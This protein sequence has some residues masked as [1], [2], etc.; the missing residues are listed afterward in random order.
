MRLLVVQTPR[1]IP[2]AKTP[3][4]YLLLP[5][6]PSLLVGRQLTNDIIVA[7]KTVSRHHLEIIWRDNDLLMR[8]LG[9]ENGTSLNSQPVKPFYPV[10]LHSG[11]QLRLG[12]VLL[13]L[14]ELGVTF[15]PRA[16]PAEILELKEVE[17]EAPGLEPVHSTTP[18][19]ALPYSEAG[20]SLT[21]LLQF[22]RISALIYLGLL[23]LAGI[24]SVSI[25]L[26]LGLTL[27]LLL[28]LGLTLQA[29]L[30]SERERPVLLALTAVP[31]YHM[32][33][34]ALPLS[35]ILSTPW[36]PVAPLIGL[37]ATLMIISHT[38][39]SLDKL[40]FRRG[41]F[42]QQTLIAASGL[43]LGAGGYFLIRPAFLADSKNLVSFA[44]AVV[45]LL[46]NS[47]NAELVLRGLVQGA[48]AECWGRKVIL[49][50]A[51]LTAAAEAGTYPLPGLVYWLLSG[52]W[53]GRAVYKT[54]SLTGA[55]IAHTI[56]S[57]MMF[58]VLPS[59]F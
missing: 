28:L 56:A 9:S 15:M 18:S 19:N 1:L 23:T 41:Y 17:Q 5:D 2:G 47:L 10:A 57:L 26:E 30:S 43:V 55:V 24:Y 35:S 27:H 20:F 11:D 31:V 4:E 25:K 59:F 8:D 13:R 14:E 52:L 45:G 3:Q 16:R 53:L 50:S 42:F 7:D 12:G 54:G 48:L 39:L 51:L 34:L 32:L 21:S 33:I 38:G 36:Y 46:L 44:P 37:L 40:G 22:P 49:F 58:L 29:A 6:K